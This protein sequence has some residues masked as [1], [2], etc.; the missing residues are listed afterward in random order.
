MCSLRFQALGRVTRTPRIFCLCKR[1]VR[2]CLP[3][4]G[5]ILSWD[6]GTAIYGISFVTSR[7][8]TVSSTTEATPASERKRTR[9]Q[10][11]I[12]SVRRPGCTRLRISSQTGQMKDLEET[13]RSDGECRRYPDW[14][15]AS[16]AQSRLFLFVVPR[17]LRCTDKLLAFLLDRYHSLWSLSSFL[18][19]S[20]LYF[21]EAWC[22]VFSL[23]F[24]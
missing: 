4:C 20:A 18:S 3:F 7:C 17:P 16:C 1:P 13:E 6:S 21:V 24:L 2:G 11:P 23:T 12:F 14:Q 22:G 15:I 8:P 5:C 9:N 19:L 10:I